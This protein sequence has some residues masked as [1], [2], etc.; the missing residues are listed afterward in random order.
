MAFS[1]RARLFLSPFR[2]DPTMLGQT[3]GV[4]VLHTSIHHVHE[5]APHDGGDDAL[6]KLPND[7][8]LA[9]LVDGEGVG[10]IVGGLDFTDG[11]GRLPAGG[12]GR[13]LF[14]LGRHCDVYAKR[15][16]VLS[17][18]FPFF[19]C[20]QGVWRGVTVEARREALAIATRTRNKTQAYTVYVITET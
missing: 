3:G 12:S 1:F 10:H 7:L 8:L 17:D 11:G 6:V 9:G 19:S 16:P 5:V 14:V 4:M 20:F 2:A 13:L 15:V 18:P